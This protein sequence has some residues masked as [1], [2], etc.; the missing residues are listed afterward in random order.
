[1]SERMLPQSIEAERGVL[2]SIIL[3]PEVLP[4]VLDK[5]LPD[6]FYRDAHRLIYEAILRV[7]QRHEPADSLTIADE[8]KR[9]GQ[10]EE[11]GDE[12]CLWGVMD[13]IPS[14]GSAAS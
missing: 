7:S 10:L 4:L 3:D 13:V 6:D 11:I 2:G 5:L 1:M 8:L 9:H 14:S 12:S